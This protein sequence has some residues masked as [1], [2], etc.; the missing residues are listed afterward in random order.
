MPKCDEKQ[1]DHAGVRYALHKYFVQH[2]GWYVRGVSD[3]EERFATLLAAAWNL[4][5]RD[6][7]EN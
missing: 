5:R 3:A 6:G 2:H 1:L 4:V 7:L